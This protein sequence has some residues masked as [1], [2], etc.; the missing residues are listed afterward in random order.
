LTIR[1][2]VPDTSDFSVVWWAWL[3]TVL[4]GFAVYVDVRENILRIISARNV[5]L[6]GIFAWYLLEAIQAKPEV[7]EYGTAAYA[8]G[9]VL[10][11]VAAAAF[12][13]GYRLFHLRW[14]DRLGWCV[15][16]LTDF[17]FLCQT[18]LVGVLVGCI[19][20]VL[21]GVADPAET[22]RGL[23]SSRHNWRGTLARPALGDFRASVLLLENFLLGVAWVAMLVIG[24]RQRS[25][26]WVLLAVAVL[27]WHLIRSYGTG[28]RSVIFLSLLIPAGWCYVRATVR[29]K[30]MLLTLAVPG[31]VLFY[32]FSAALVEGRE[33]G[34]LAFDRMPA[35]V[36]HE[37]FREFLFVMDE[38]PGRRDFLYGETLFVE[39][40]NPIP[41]FLW[42]DKPVGFGVEYASWHGADALRGGPTLSPGI[43]GEM[44]INFG[45]PGIVFLS[46]I[47]GA[48]ARAWDRLGPCTRQCVPISLFYVLGLGCF[49]MMGRSFSI[50]LFYQLIASLICMGVVA[51]RTGRVQG[52]TRDLAFV[53]PGGR[54]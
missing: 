29:Q 1:I 41:R 10:V 3:A 15:I 14:F 47:G 51:Y 43:I 23:I 40:V 19:P 8:R 36:G 33:E 5:I 27:A 48:I 2:R 32:W 26:R 38:V 24:H 7:R 52:G 44:Y 45:T 39:L 54:S 25:R 31:A 53:S 12:L 21:Y 28:S 34:R 13:G 16:R 9:I 30:C 4:I 11:L 42:Q 20:V 18:L 50:R 49:L 46:M 17:R 6:I 37:M 22:L 35:Y